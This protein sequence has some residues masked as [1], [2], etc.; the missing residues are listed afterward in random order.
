MDA[1][2]EGGGAAVSSCPI[3][4]ARFQ[5]AGTGRPRRFCS[6]ACKARAHRK[7]QALERRN[8]TPE[9]DVLRDVPASRN[10]IVPLT[11]PQANALVAKWHRHHHPLRI[12]RFSIGLTND[13][14]ELIGAAIMQKPASASSDQHLTLEVARLVVN[15]SLP[16]RGDGHANAACSRLYGACAR[17]AKEMGFERIQT[18]ILD[19]EPGTS[20]KA[21]G[22]TLDR[23][24]KW[25]KWDHRADG[26][27]RRDE[28]AQDKQRWVRTLREP[29]LQPRT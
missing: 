13:E 23:R 16:P 3:C 21:A 28:L 4:K 10:S 9:R 7:R 17:I 14:G 19:T 25:S 12:H 24:T 26:R 22:W 2:A 27:L 5:R 6:D 15:P 8:P 29:R 1:R 18:F 11:L 20:L